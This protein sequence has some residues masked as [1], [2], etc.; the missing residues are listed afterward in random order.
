M[1]SRLIRNVGARAYF[2]SCTE[3]W[4]H[5]VD[6]GYE[7][8]RMSAAMAAGHTLEFGCASALAPT[9]RDLPISETMQSRL[10]LLRKTLDDLSGGQDLF[11]ICGPLPRAPDVLPCRG[12]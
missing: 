12:L 5:A 1:F 10:V 2:W 7:D 6:V 3:G 9:S 11:D 8:R 4:L